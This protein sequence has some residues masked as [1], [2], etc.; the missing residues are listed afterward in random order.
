MSQ[1][2]MLKMFISLVD[3]LHSY[4]NGLSPFSFSSFAGPSIAHIR[5]KESPAHLGE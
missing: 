2:K 5:L 1:I 3:S 4:I